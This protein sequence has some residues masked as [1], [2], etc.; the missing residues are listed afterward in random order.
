MRTDSMLT[1]LKLYLLKYTICLAALHSVQT[2]LRLIRKIL[3]SSSS[4]VERGGT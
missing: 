2:W 1:D 4:E 3:S